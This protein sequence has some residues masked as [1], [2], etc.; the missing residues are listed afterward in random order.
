MK[1]ALRRSSATPIFLLLLLSCPAEADTGLIKAEREKFAELR[2]QALALE[3]G[4]GVQKDLTR[5]IAL[6]C[7]A[8]HAGDIESQFN[9]GWIYANGRGVARDDAAAMYLFARAAEQGHQHASKVLSLLGD[10]EGHMPECLRSLPKVEV[11]QE[12]LEPPRRVTFES[13]RAPDVLEPLPEELAKT[14]VQTQAIRL[15]NKLGAEYGVSPRLAFAVIRAESNF[16]P[17]AVSPKNAQ[18]LM[19]LIPETS[20]RFNVKK[21]FDPAQNVRGGLAYLRWLLS[22]F[23]GNVPLVL[24]AYNAGEGTVN[25]YRGIPPFTET[26]AYVKRIIQFFGGNNHPYDPTVTDPSPQLQASRVAGGVLP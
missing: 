15:V 10:G 5:A 18:G 19:Q 13:V 23:E 17:N 12:P 2:L 14:P 11:V 6:Y 3:H 4:E 25:R 16:N 8:A 9:L 24:A 1:K 22:Y 26:R 20:T 7:E 21:P